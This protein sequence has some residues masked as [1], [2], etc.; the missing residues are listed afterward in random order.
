MVSKFTDSLPVTA[1]PCN[2]T[3]APNLL[4]NYRI[5]KNFGGKKSVANA[6]FGKIWQKK[7]FGDSNNNRQSFNANFFSCIRIRSSCE[8]IN[9][10]ASFAVSCQFFS[11][12]NNF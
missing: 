11:V 6:L 3:G 10:K 4:V 7:N 2:G 5:V 12:V 8:L 9:L 1:V